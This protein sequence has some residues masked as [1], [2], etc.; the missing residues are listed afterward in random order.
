MLALLLLALPRPAAAATLVVGPGQPYTRIQDAIDA[1]ASGDTVSIRAGTY[2]E[3]LDTSGKDLVLQGAGSGSVTVTGGSDQN[4]LVDS[5]ESV[6]VRGLTLRGAQQSA[7]VRAST[8]TFDDVVFTGASGVVSGGGLGVYDGATVTLT[9]CEITGN[10]V[11]GSYNGGGLY[12]DAS[13]ATLDTVTISGNSATQGG[14]IYASEATLTLTDVTVSSNSA[15][16]HG[17]GLRVR[18]RSSVTATRAT[19]SDNA[20]S[21]RG[22]GASFVGSDGTWTA[23]SFE[24]NTAGTSGG[25]LH[26][27]GVL[28]AGT[29][30]DG[31]LADNDA[32]GSGGA[33]FLNNHD[34][35]LSGDVTDNLVGSTGN[36]G[37]LYGI[38]SNVS[39][40]DATIS[41]HSAGEGGGVYLYAGAAL[42]M[43]RGEISGNEATGSGGGIYLEGSLSLEDAVLATNLSGGSGGGAWVDGGSLSVDG[44]TVSDN[45]ASTAEA[46]GGIALSDGAVDVRSTTF[47]GNTGG[48]GGGMAVLGTGADAA[49]FRNVVFDGNTAAADGGGLYVSNVRSF[50]LHRSTLSDN[51]AGIAGGGAHVDDGGDTRLQFLTVMGNVATIAGGLNISGANGGFTRQIDVAANSSGGARYASPDGAHDIY[52]ARFWDNTGDGLVLRADPAGHLTVTNVDASG[53]DGSGLVL[54]QAPLAAVVN[55]IAATNADAGIEA[56]ATTAGSM[57]LR[58]C[59][60]H[61]NDDDWGGALPDLAGVDFNLSVDPEYALL[62]PD[63]DPGTDLIVLGS[64]SPC[65]DAGDPGLLDPDGSRSDMGSYGGPDAGDA[66][67]DGDGYSIA[68]GD[69]DESDPSAHPGAEETWYDGVDQDCEVGDDWDADGDGE[70]STLHPDGGDCDDTDPDVYP[71]ADDDSVDGVD[72]D[73]DGTDGP[74]GGDDGGGTGGEGGGGDDGGGDDGSEDEDVDGDGSPAS[75][76]CNDAEPRAYPGADETCGD[77]IDNDCDGFTDD[78]DADC[79]PK[80]DGGCSVAPAPAGGGLAL[81][82]LGLSA[83]RRRR[84]P[85]PSSDR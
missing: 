76:D 48:Y 73:C 36:G 39:L 52:N 62:V 79:I 29:D 4:L 58:Y 10:T 30:F 7:E 80:D 70:R 77:G 37:A 56:D 57:V 45:A 64:T 24:A 25:G 15:S 71:G 44:A 55:V 2:V 43:V 81:L 82:A 35:T 59:D 34:L 69:C 31:T 60:A 13:V 65:R 21:G 20:A 16:T 9:D 61:G 74:G 78:L 3:A 11:T 40:T 68:D 27:D 63:G 33:V 47:E 66:D 67:L 1:A 23:S 41:G 28:S 26:L 8:A 12:V 49:E 22:G 32:G 18:N 19:V 6:T 14:G 85:R 53:N 17:G 38:G 72:Q 5:G 75:V 83:A 42:A 54:E 51:E 84:R 50:L 46:G